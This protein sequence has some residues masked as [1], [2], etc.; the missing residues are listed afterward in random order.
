M[1]DKVVWSLY[2]CTHRVV[3]EGIQ[4]V[5]DTKFDMLVISKYA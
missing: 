5:V 4:C 2:V 3:F 1:V